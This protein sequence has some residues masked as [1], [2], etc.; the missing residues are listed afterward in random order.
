MD[1]ALSTLEPRVILNYLSG[2]ADLVNSWL[3]FLE[4]L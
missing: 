3:Q 1:K 4:E 2:L